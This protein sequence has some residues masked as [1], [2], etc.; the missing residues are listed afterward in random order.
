M[1]ALPLVVALAGWSVASNRFYRWDGQIQEFGAGPSEVKLPVK[2]SA[3]AEEQELP[4][5]LYNDLS[6]GGYLAWGRP[7]GTGVYFDG[8]LEVYDDQFFAN[9]LAHQKQ[10]ALWQ[11]H[12]D[13]M[14]FQTVFL[15]HWYSSQR[16]LLRWLLRDRR[17][18]LV[19]FDENTVVFIRRDGNEALVQRVAQ[20]FASLQESHGRALL[21]TT[22]SWQWPLERVQ[23]LR[24]YGSVLDFMGRHDEAM[25]FLSRALELGPSS[26]AQGVL[27]VR[28]GQYHAGRG[29]LE[30]AR[31]YLRRAEQADPGNPRIAPLR[32][33][34]GR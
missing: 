13:E 31:W 3:F 4:P 28:L 27:A 34:V 17:W 26:K 19:Y 16:P 2:A 11:D 6:T 33:R 25:T 5:P 10:P 24:V 1:V 9:Y 22:S 8:R 30:Q 12:A 21:E 18:A 20:R 15:Y 14:G 29:E 7:L 32:K 23:A